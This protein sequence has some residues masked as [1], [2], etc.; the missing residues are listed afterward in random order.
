MMK[1]ERLMEMSKEELVKIIEEKESKIKELNGMMRNIME[2][3]I[4]L[5]IISF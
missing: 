2:Y 5:N 4:L 1:K 3:N